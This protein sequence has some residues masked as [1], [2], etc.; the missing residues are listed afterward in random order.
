MA[1][2]GAGRHDAHVREGLLA[3]AQKAVP[4]DVA[5]EL[6]GRVQFQGVRAPVDV[7]DHGMVDHEID[8]H[9]RVDRARVA[10]Q[11]LDGV[12]HGGEVDDAGNP[13][14]V[15][16]KDSG[17]RVGDLTAGGAPRG[18]MRPRLLCRRPARSRH[19]RGAA[20]SPTRA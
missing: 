19:P 17:R 1:D 15:L 10:P 13:G 7:G 18:V 8:G 6:E 9:D 11:M 12:P 20:G 5:L 3:P 16:E 2:S 14:E 4:L